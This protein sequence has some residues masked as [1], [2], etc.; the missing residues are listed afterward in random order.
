[1]RIYAIDHVQLSMPKSEEDKA[2]A[3]YA[4]LLGFDETPKPAELAGRGG[5]WFEQG[6]VRLHLGVEADFHPL[7]KAHP[8]LL[9]DDLAALILHLQTNDCEVDTSQ[10]PLDGYRRV[11]VLDPFGNRLELMEKLG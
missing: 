9:V 3:F 4:G 6:Q 8:A 1:M 5:V 11:H 7:K 10:P 2:R